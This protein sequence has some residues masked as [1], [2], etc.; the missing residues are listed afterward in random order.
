MTECL[1]LETQLALG[2]ASSN[3]DSPPMIIIQVTLFRV[4]TRGQGRG[5]VCLLGG[6]AVWSAV[7]PLLRGPEAGHRDQRPLGPGQLRHQAP[8]GG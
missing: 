1:A 7:R 3:P 6:C 4:Q 5:R 8:S 2:L